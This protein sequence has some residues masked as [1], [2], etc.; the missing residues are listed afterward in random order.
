[1][2]SPIFSPCGGT[3]GHFGAPKKGWNALVQFYDKTINFLKSL[4][5]WLDEGKIIQYMENF[6]L[7]RA[8]ARGDPRLIAFNNRI[9]VF[10]FNFHLSPMCLKSSHEAQITISTQQ[11][12]STAIID[13]RLKSKP[14]CE[15]QILAIG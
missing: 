8:V 11:Q 4:S 14:R 7:F 15:A 5:L 10:P 13:V 6:V 12:D 9:K 3:N 2:T 1:M